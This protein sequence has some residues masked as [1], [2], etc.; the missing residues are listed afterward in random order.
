V[1]IFGRNWE[2]IRSSI[3]R[4]PGLFACCVRVLFQIRNPGRVLICYLRRKPL[5]S[6][7]VEFRNGL[8][9]H[10]S[11]HPDDLATIFLIFLRSTYSGLESDTVVLDI[12]ANI[13][14]FSLYAAKS[15]KVQKVYAIEPCRESMEILQRNIVANQL[16]DIIVP[17]RAVVCGSKPG[18]LVQFP[19]V[20]DPSNNSLNADG[21]P[22]EPVITTTIG[23]VV[24][25]KSLGRV[26]YVKI[27][28]E[29]AEYEIIR[30][31]PPALFEQFGKV[32][33]EYHA[34]RQSELIE[35]MRSQNFAVTGYTKVLPEVGLLAFERRA[36]TTR[37]TN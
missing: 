35:R 36:L 29:G 34:G 9:I 21:F 14:A 27:D 30:E 24:E 7:I 26:D 32:V 25:R 10:V 31:M 16:Q 18:E 11:R 20:S 8:K 19:V 23:E 33:V 22:T 5:P 13:G 4:I 1:R 2:R 12:G 17:L 37:L 28:C 6:G 15:A 3:P